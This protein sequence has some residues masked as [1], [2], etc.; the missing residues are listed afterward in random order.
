MFLTQE[1]L[2]KEGC[3]KLKFETGADLPVFEVAEFN[4]R[5]NFYIYPPRIP[6]ER[7]G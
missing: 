7:V 2:K 1:H 5:N 4:S 3:E 6:L